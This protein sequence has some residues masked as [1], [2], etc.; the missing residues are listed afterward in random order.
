MSR[1]QSLGKPTGLRAFQVPIL[2]ATLTL[3]G[4]KPTSEGP[5]ASGQRCPTRRR[6]IIVVNDLGTRLGTQLRGRALA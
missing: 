1:S 3:P 4:G 2:K 6:H 5:R